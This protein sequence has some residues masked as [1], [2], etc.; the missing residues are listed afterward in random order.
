MV[1]SWGKKKWLSNSYE[2]RKFR[3]ISSELSKRFVCYKFLFSN[4]KRVL[5][6]WIFQPLNG[7][8]VLDSVFDNFENLKWLTSKR[9]EMCILLK[10][11][12]FARKK[13]TFC[14]RKFLSKF[15]SQYKLLAH[16]YMKNCDVIAY[17]KFHFMDSFGWTTAENN[18]I[19]VTCE[20]LLLFHAIFKLSIL[21]TVMI[22]YL[23]NTKVFY[24]KKLE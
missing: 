4:V 5:S 1:Y 22:Q 17:D 23:M 7:L 21:F 10:E 8:I 15:I 20:K 12:L 9:C 13:S 6:E 11:V 19:R 18:M 14:M 2:Y 24:Q 16:N 3:T